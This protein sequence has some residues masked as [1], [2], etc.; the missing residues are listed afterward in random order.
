MSNENPALPPGGAPPGPP[1]SNGQKVP[2]SI[3]DE[4]RRLHLVTR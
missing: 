4:M 1:S 3:Q 2:I